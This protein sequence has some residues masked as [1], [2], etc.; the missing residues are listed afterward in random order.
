MYNLQRQIFDSSQNINTIYKT[1][2][3]RTEVT[4]CCSQHSHRS[5]STWGLNP[6]SI[7]IFSSDRFGR[8]GLGLPNTRSHNIRRSF[9]LAGVAPSALTFFQLIIFFKSS[10]DHLYTSFDASNFSSSLICC[11][12]SLYSCMLFLYVL[13]HLT[14]A[15]SFLSPWTSSIILPS[16]EEL[17][18]KI[19]PPMTRLAF[20]CV[21]WRSFRVTVIG[22]T[23]SGGYNIRMRNAG[24]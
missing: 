1:I 22:N 24:F 4:W 21:F 16:L 12:L 11:F 19:A 23:I 6:P 5:P 17:L 2:Q 20:L 18:W 9:F 13:Y 7:S 8:V 3:I 15:A 14:R 10:T